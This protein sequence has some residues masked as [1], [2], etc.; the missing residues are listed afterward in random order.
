LRSVIASSD[1]TFPIYVE[2][3]EPTNLVYE[4]YYYLLSAFS[5]PNH[6]KNLSRDSIKEKLKKISTKSS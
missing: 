2:E 1:C 4:M 6:E 3:L 5:Y